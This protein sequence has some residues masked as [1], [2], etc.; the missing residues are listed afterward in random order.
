MPRPTSCLTEAGLD[1]RVVL[2]LLRWCSDLRICR[3]LLRS[4][5]VG[6]ESLVGLAGGLT[7]YG[8]YWA[9]A[10]ALGSEGF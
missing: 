3:W 10:G 5:R 9:G 4:L 1:F 7:L 6:L 2:S 8:S